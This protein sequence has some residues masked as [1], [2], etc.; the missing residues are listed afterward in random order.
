[1]LGGKFYKF[2]RLDL[3]CQ[4]RL[5]PTVSEPCGH[6]MGAAAAASLNLVVA[7]SDYIVQAEEMK[8][9]VA[10]DFFGFYHFEADKRKEKKRFNYPC[11]EERKKK[12]KPK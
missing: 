5:L 4:H 9:P 12:K 7:H 6:E 10:F 1:M 8:R 2:R 11:Y 3:S